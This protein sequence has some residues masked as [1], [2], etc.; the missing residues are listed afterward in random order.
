MSADRS[1]V[2]IGE[3]LWDLLPSGKQLGGAPA[4][5]A[6]HAAQ[7]GAQAALVSQ[8]GADELGE[9]ALA[10]LRERRVEVDHVLTDSEHPTGTVSVELD[11]G[12]E[13]VYTIHEDV[14][15][16]FIGCPPASMELTAMADAV[17]FGTLAQRSERSRRTIRRLL[18][19]TAPGCL[20]LLDVNLRQDFYD[21][22]LLHDALTTASVLKVNEEELRAIG[23]LLE[24]PGADNALA[25]KVAGAFSLTAVAVTRGRRGALLR[26]FDDEVEHAGFADGGKATAGSSGTPDSRAGGQNVTETPDMVGAGD[27]FS[28]ALCV[29]LL[30]GD[31]P[32]LIVENANRLAAYVC[33]QPGAMPPLPHD[34]KQNL[35]P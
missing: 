2:A 27:A 8:V 10:M 9:E 14:A 30:Q 7:L 22:E 25:R 13:P 33:S 17:C 29:G 21:A 24:I 12:G 15:W 34:L 26:V 35:T 32:E 31:T 20:R 23:E 18:D 3:L 28:A 16:D 6:Y 5:F 11:E 1:V 19:I 4:N